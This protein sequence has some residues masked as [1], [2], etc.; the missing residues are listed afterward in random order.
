MLGTG[1]RHLRER[2][3]LHGQRGQ[4]FRFERMNIGLAAGAG[5]K[6]RLN[7]QGVQEVIDPD[8]GL[9]RVQA[10][11]QFRVLGGD[12]DRAAAGMAVV[13]IAR[14]DAQF[15]FIIGLGDI[16]V[17]V[18]GH[19]GRVAYRNRIG[20]ERD[21]LGQVRAVADPAGIDQRYFAFHAHFLNGA[22]GL[23]DRGD[24]RHPG[25]F[26]GQM[27]PGPGAAFHAVYIDGVG[28]GLGRHAHVIIDPGRAQF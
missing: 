10:R 15:I 21:G 27:R 24:A 28:I 1:Q 20:A 18:H 3:R 14:L 16:L 2:G 5:K 11:A 17:A 9:V 23:P 4:V 25:V 6:L 7:R 8:R 13:T 19:H 22:A 26:R 12:A